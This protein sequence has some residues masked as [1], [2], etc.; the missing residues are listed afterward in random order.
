MCAFISI[1]PRA[2]PF[3]FESRNA[4]SLCF[5]AIP[6]AKPLRTFAGIALE[7]DAEKC[8]RFSGD[9]ML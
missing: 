5:H 1:I 6:G 2:F 9:T 4:L 7:H 8:Q 3:F